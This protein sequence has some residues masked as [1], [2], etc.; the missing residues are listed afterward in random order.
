MRRHYLIGLGIFLPTAAW[1]WPDATEWVGVDGIPDELSEASVSPDYLD[2]VG[3]STDPVVQWS[4]DDTM[5]AFRV[6]VSDSPTT[7]GVL[8]TGNWT[9]LVDL[10]GVDEDFEFALGVTGPTSVLEAY[11]NVD[12]DDGPAPP[13]TTYNGGYGGILTDF[14]R[15]CERLGVRW[16]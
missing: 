9:I 15:E 11:E 2:L 7:L 16:S 10:D 1:A 3:D 5:V 8:K 14:A 4:A 13:I 12:G 6:R